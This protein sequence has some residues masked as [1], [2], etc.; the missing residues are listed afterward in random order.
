VA[1]LIETARA[2]G[3][4]VLQG[5]VRYARLHG[6]WAFYVTP[7]DLQQVLPRMEDWGGGGII[8]RIENRETAE[9][10]LAAGLPMVAI[11]PDRQVLPHDRRAESL[12][13]LD[14]DSHGAG[15]MAADHL[16]E[17]GLRQF[18]FVGAFDSPLWSV[19]R[20]E[21]F[22]QRLAEVGFTCSVYPLPD[23]PSDRQWGLEQGALGRWIR[24]LPKPVGLLACNDDR[25][26]EAL[27]ACR[28]AEVQV[29]EDVAVIGVDNDEL[30]CELSDPQLSS[31]AFDTQKAG[32]MAAALLDGLMSG[33]IHE[34]QYI[35]TEPIRVVA[36]RSTD[37]LA[38]DDRTVATA[39]RFIHDHPRRPLSVGDVVRQVP[40]SRRALEVRFRR[41][42]GRTI[43]EEIQRV[44]L[45]YVRR[46]IRETDLPL[47]RIAQQCAFGNA[48]QLTR[49][50]FNAFHVLPSHYRAQRSS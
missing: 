15:R 32:Y 19:R 37:I 6:P 22:C 20:Q 29:P 50:F 12:S 41:V 25:G 47:K 27:V 28:G 5:I 18:A 49:A 24:G 3:R 46:L 44:R 1:L 34:P 16:L 8:G 40:L 11:I 7:G 48:G 36:R 14:A 13:E 45:E 35:V 31:V 10:V 39:L 42:V 33:R 21:G 4:G 26:R 2:Y 30:L 9:A 43:H 23:R 38:L 17:H